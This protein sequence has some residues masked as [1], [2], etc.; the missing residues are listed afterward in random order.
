MICNLRMSLH[1]NSHSVASIAVTLHD[2][3][4]LKQ[5]DCFFFVRFLLKELNKN[6]KTLKFALQQQKKRL[7]PVSELR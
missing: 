5:P 7:G 6:K 2:R 1:D 4:V 3:A